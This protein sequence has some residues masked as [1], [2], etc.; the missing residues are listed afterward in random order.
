[1]KE[2]GT[3][4]FTSQKKKKIPEKIGML[5]QSQCNEENKNKP[6]YQPLKINKTN[7]KL[8]ENLL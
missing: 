6:S 3:K 1:M 7:S 2:I 5:N 8:V 4:D